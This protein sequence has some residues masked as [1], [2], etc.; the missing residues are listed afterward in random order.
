[1]GVGAP[2]TPTYTPTIAGSEPYL[3]LLRNGKWV[4]GT[5]DNPIADGTKAIINPLSIQHGYSCWTDRAPNDGENEKLGEQ[6]WKITQPK[7]GAHELPAMVDPR[8]QNP[9]AW[10]FQMS[11]ELKLMDGNYKDQHA[12]YAVTCVVGLR[13]VNH[14][15]GELERKLGAGST[16]IFPIVRVGSDS[17]QYGR[18]A[19]TSYVPIVEIVGW[20]DILGAEEAAD[21]P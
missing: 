16:Y 8:T 1:L 13:L 5:E 19:K 17:Y 18:F 2:Q 12:I 6:M 20:A 7:A 10:K 4:M 11:F 9:C 15:M 14:I 21:K 3:R